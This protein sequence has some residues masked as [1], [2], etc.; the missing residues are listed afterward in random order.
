ML[1]LTLKQEVKAIIAWQYKFNSLNHEKLKEFVC[2]LREVE[3]CV[4]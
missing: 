2:K 1:T 3:T 4:E